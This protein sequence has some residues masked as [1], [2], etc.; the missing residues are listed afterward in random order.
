MNNLWVYYW[1]YNF[2]IE[3]INYLYFI[4]NLYKKKTLPDSYKMNVRSCNNDVNVKWN[5]LK[6]MLHIMSRWSSPLRLAALQKTYL[7]PKLIRYAS[8]ALVCSQSHLFPFL[9][10]FLKINF[11]GNVRNRNLSLSWS[12]RVWYTLLI[13]LNRRLWMLEHFFYYFWISTPSHFLLLH[14]HL[15]LLLLLL[16]LLFP[17]R[18]NLFMRLFMLARLFHH[19][20]LRILLL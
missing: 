16:L 8:L 4:N 2:I 3:K 11:L 17:T 12:H 10:K 5:E 13:Q 15:L 20:D 9:L 18:L 1:Y 7:R 19:W 6:V 14:F